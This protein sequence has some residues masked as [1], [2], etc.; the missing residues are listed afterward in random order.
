MVSLSQDLK[1]LP[2]RLIDEQIS[3]ALET[4]ESLVNQREILKVGKSSSSHLSLV[5]LILISVNFDPIVIDEIS[6]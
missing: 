5:S 1:M 6:V 2:A 4:R 3:I